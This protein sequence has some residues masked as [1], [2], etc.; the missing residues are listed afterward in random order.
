MRIQAAAAPAGIPTLDAAI[1]PEIE[2]ALAGLDGDAPLLGRMA[3]YHLGQ[4]DADGKPT[5][6]GA[7]DRG[8]RIRPKVAILCCAAAGG[9][10]ALA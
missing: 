5:T 1:D 4:A 6:P 7:V 10:P 8:K 9:D 2:R 3:R